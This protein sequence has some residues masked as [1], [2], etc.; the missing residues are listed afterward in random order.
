MSTFTQRAQ[1]TKC[2]SQG[3]CSTG[4]RRGCTEMSKPWRC[5]LTQ[6]KTQARNYLSSLRIWS[7]RPLLPHHHHLESKRH[8]ASGWEWDS[9]WTVRSS[10][11]DLACCWLQGQVAGQRKCSFSGAHF[12]LVIKLGL[13][14]SWHHWWNLERKRDTSGKP[15][16]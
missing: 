13:M 7:N 12:L 14:G 6:W 3:N 4:V 1:M 5:P 16:Y 8:L 15:F 9:S 11:T 2:Q 10:W